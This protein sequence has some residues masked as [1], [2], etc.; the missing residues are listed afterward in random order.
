MVRVIIRVSFRVK[1]NANPN[2]HW[3]LGPQVHRLPVAVIRIWALNSFRRHYFQPGWNKSMHKKNKYCPNSSPVYWSRHLV[4]H[5]VETKCSHAVAGLALSQS[6]YD[7]RRTALGTWAV[8]RA[9]RIP[10]GIYGSQVVNL[11]L[12]MPMLKLV[13]CL[14]FI[15]RYLVECCIP[16]GDVARRH[17]RSAYL[18]HLTVPRYRRSTIGSVG[19]PASETFVA[20]LKTLLFARY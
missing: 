4:C 6:K 8:Y 3:V 20:R 1:I 19:G 18:H 11:A 16:V 10:Y 17:R 15:S 5:S 2:I 13:S 9:W 12:L 7:V 14:S